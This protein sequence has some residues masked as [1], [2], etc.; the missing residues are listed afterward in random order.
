MT[1]DPGDRLT[2]EVPWPRFPLVTKTGRVSRAGNAGKPIPWLSGNIIHNLLSGNP[3]SEKSQA[4]GRIRVHQ[5]K[6]L[7]REAFAQAAREAVPTETIALMAAEGELAFDYAIFADTRWEPGRV[8]RHLDWL[9]AQVPFPILQ[10]GKGNLRLDALDTEHRFA[11]LPLFV[12]RPDGRSGIL[13]RQCTKEYK[14]YP[15]RAKA[16]ELGATRKNP[17]T[18]AIGFSV[19]ELGRLTDSSVLYLRHEFPLV[20]RR[21]TRGDC[22][23][24]LERRGYPQPPKSACLACPLHSDAM[25][26]QIRADAEEWAEVV[27]FDHALREVPRLRARFGAEVY[28]HPSLRAI[29]EV[30][31]STAED[32]GQ[33]RLDLRTDASCSPFAC[34][35]A[36]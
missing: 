33:M 23:L 5:I 25:W 9:S 10:C 22:L 6:V 7:W 2:L 14:L 31:L 17:A 34:R 35:S 36:A 27:A 1:I 18:M 15:I 20:D 8:Y 29:D 26:R 32:A 30:D 11:S 16:K 19:D 12:R 28:L 3:F 4:N 21:M 13:R 24:W